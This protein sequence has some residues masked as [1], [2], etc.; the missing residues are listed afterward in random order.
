MA[1]RRFDHDI[2]SSKDGTLVDLEAEAL[3]FVSE[4][5]DLF[6][7]VFLGVVR[8]ALLGSRRPGRGAT[9]P[10]QGADVRGEGREAP[11]RRAR[12]R[13]MENAMAEVQ[14]PWPD[15]WETRR[16]GIS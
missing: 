10:A 9:E 16:T 1:L 8:V 7:R 14:R 11:R 13:S 5:R 4:K 2:A 3:R 6:A 12:G 15:S